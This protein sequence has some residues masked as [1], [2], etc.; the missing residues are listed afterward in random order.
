MGDINIQINVREDQDVQTLLDTIAAFNLKQHVNIPTHNLGHTLDPII[1]PAT[2]DR[3]LIAGP[4]VSDHWFVTLETSH[5]KP[6]PKQE[7]RT[8]EKFTDETITQLKNKFNILPILEI[9]TFNMAANQLNNEMLKTIEKIYPA[10]TKTITNRHKKPGMM[11][12]LKDKE[13]S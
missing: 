8:V 3:S 12:T 9:T 4:Y 6:K 2:Y 13:R 1:T 11:K 7:N 5:T 10:T